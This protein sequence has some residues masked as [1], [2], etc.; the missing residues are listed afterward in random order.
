MRYVDVWRIEREYA[1]IYRNIFEVFLDIK[2]RQR[3]CSNGLC[4]VLHVGM[5][6]RGAHTFLIDDN[7]DISSGGN[8][9]YT[10]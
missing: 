3:E 8:K 6:G 4:C 10:V 1:Q 2:R 5:S 9:A 7:D